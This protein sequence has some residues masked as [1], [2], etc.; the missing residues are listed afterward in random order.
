[1]QASE[2]CLQFVLFQAYLN[3]QYP[4]VASKIAIP[5]DSSDSN[6]PDAG[7]SQSRPED[8]PIGL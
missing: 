1:M 7:L 4:E 5:G 8:A 2:T 3:L 6:R